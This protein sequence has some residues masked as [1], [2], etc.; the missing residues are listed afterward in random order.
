MKAGVTVQDRATYMLG[1][2]TWTHAVS[3]GALPTGYSAFMYADGNVG[4]EVNYRIN[5]NGVETINGAQMTIRSGPPSKGAVHIMLAY[6]NIDGKV[7]RQ[8]ERFAP[9]GGRP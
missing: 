2:P 1:E 4:M 7:T 8:V 6:F 5:P 9:G 3:H